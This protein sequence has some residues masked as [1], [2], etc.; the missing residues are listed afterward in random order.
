[1]RRNVLLFGGYRS[2]SIYG[3]HAWVL[4][5]QHRQHQHQHI[6]DRS[7]SRE[8]RVRT[9]SWAGCEATTMQMLSLTD[10]ISSK[11]YNLTKLRAKGVKMTKGGCLC[12]K[13]TFEFSSVPVK[14]VSTMFAECSYCLSTVLTAIAPLPLYQ[15]QTS[16]GYCVLDKYHHP[17]QVP[18][19]RR[20]ATAIRLRL[21]TW[22]GLH[23]LVLRDVLEHPVERKRR[24]GAQ[25][26]HPRASWCIDAR[27]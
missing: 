22:T 20:I 3:R 2:C 21:R 4:K 6:Q 24:R 9:S 27:L 7:M 15:L 25:R 1:M 10:F 16:D 14:K 5:N 17:I 26:I 11:K 8:S 19:L 13:I 12:G 18:A 23:D